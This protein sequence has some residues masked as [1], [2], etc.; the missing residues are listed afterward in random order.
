MANMATQQGQLA[1]Q[2]GQMGLQGLQTQAGMYGQQGQ[3]AQQ[4]SQIGLQYGQ[5]S[6]QDINQAAAMAQQK[7][8]MAQGIGSLAGQTGQLAGQLG[9]LGQMQAGL[10][11]QAQQQRMADYNAL[12]NYGGFEQQQGQNILNSQYQADKAAY[13]QPFQQIAF[14]ADLTKA[15]PSS[16]FAQFQQQTPQAST[17]Q[18]VAGIGM[19][20]AG[21]AK[22][23]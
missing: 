10:G 4:G 13:D 9:S 19:G 20:V 11:Q 8:G 21:M 12:M 18:Q 17:A 1:Q 14:M 6:Q 16:Q 3:L 23:F 2:G 22:A 15:L 7:A 5:L